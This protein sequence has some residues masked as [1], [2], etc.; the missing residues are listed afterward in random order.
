MKKMTSLKKLVLSGIVSISCLLPALSQALTF[1]QFQQEFGKQP[2]IKAQFEQDR[3]IKGLP[4]PLHSTGSM[5]MSREQGLWWQQQTPFPLTLYLNDEK[6]VQT[7][8]GQAPQIITAKSQP[9][10]FQFNRLL[11]ALFNADKKTLEENFTLNFTSTDEQWSLLLYPKTSPLDKLF[12]QLSLKGG[13][14]L[15][16]IIIDDMQGD[17][18]VIN[19]NH[20]QTTPLTA[21]EQKYFQ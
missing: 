8:A 10:L 20:H 3:A 7:I 9:Q 14:F 1:E 21:D 16:Q 6:M 12:K 2:I 5:I 19:F 11:T 13:I 15:E 17:Q 4:T 18:T